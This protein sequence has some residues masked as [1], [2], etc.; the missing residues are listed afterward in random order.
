MPTNGAANPAGLD[1]NVCVELGFLRRLEQPL[2]V[3]SPLRFS[4]SGSYPV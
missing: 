4:G 3:S 1:A 2:R